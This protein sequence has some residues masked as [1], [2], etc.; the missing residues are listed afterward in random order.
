VRSSAVNSTVTVTVAPGVEARF[1]PASNVVNTAGIVRPVASPIMFSRPVR[2]GWPSFITITALAPA[3][4]ALSTLTLK[5]HVP[6]WT[7]AIPPAGKPA[8]SAASQPLVEEFAG[9]D[10]LITRSTGTSTPVAV[11]SGVPESNVLRRK[12]VSL[13]NVLSCG[14][15]RI[16]S[17]FS[18]K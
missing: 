15:T 6:R 13:M 10:G 7:S 8:K 1:W 12:S 3:A 2:P 9:P 4:C 17:E 11:P 5:P 18:S 16:S 14:L